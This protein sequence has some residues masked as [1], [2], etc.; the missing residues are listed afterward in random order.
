MSK[1]DKPQYFGVDG[2]WMVVS[3]FV[4]VGPIKA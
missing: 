3:G 2:L 1:G 4:A